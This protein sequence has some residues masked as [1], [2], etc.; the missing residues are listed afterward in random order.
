MKVK[1]IEDKSIFEESGEREYPSLTDGKEYTVLETFETSNGDI[2]YEIAEI[3]Y[4]GKPS[5][6]GNYSSELSGYPIS[7]ETL[8]TMNRFAFGDG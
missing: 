6:I 3:D 5:S 2:E 1:Y 4:D 8:K 7:E